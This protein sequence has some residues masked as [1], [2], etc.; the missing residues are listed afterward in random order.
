MSNHDPLR[1]LPRTRV[2]EF[3][4]RCIIYEPSRPPEYLYL[5]LAGRVKVFSTAEDGSQ[6]LLRIVPAEG[7]FGESSLI[8]MRDSLRQTATVLEAAQIMCWTAEQVHQQIEREPKLGLALFQYFCT[9]NSILRDRV[10]TV[11]VYKTGIRV[12]LALLQLAGCIGSETGDG[13]V[14]LTGLTHQA[15][16]DY[17]GTSREI[18]TAEMNHLRRMGYLAY[19]RR[20]TDIYASALREWLR[21]QGA[22]TTPAV[23]GTAMTA[24]S[25][26][27]A[28]G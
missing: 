17:V 26:V 23:S 10:I 4:A 28:A 5:V 25:G 21:E 16:A 11:A 27:N 3:P 19:T 9:N 1:Y 15:I 2:N 7:F 6:T 22:E 20:F 12:A 8:P 18:V 24:T 14:R 13:A